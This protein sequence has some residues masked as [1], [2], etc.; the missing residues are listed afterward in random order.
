MGYKFWA[1]LEKTEEA[2]KIVDLV[3]KKVGVKNMCF[4]SSPCRTIGCMDGKK[5]WL[6]DHYQHLAGQVLFG[7]KKEFCANPEHLLIDDY[8]ENI[9]KFREAGGQAILFPRPWNS[10]YLIQQP[11][12]YLIQ[13]LENV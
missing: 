9:K 7:N 6:L 10:N 3:V 1:E 4:L 8:D 13:E 12:D 5:R 11:L 2:D